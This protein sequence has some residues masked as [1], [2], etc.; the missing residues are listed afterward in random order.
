MAA[1]KHGFSLA[2]GT[3]VG[4]GLRH[5]VSAQW[6]LL[7]ASSGRVIAVGLCAG[8]VAQIIC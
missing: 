7:W 2:L 6:K 8:L 1:F 4:H 3:T 5:P